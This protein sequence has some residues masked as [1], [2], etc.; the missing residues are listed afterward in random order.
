MAT[1]QSVQ[2]LINDIQ[3]NSYFLPEF[4]RG[5][6]WTSDQIKKFF[7]SLYR[8][9]PTG[10]FLV[11]KSENPPKVRGTTKSERGNFTKLIL[12][13]QQRLT[14]L[15]TI[16]KGTPPPWFEGKTP[17]TDLF[18]NLETEEFKYYQKTLMLGKREWIGV[19]AFLQQGIGD[20]VNNAT[21]EEKGYL[22]SHF[23][24]L[25][26]LQSIHSYEYYIQ[27][28]DLQDSLKVVDIFNLVNS[29]GTP[30][31]QADLSLALITSRWEECKEKMRG[32]AMKYKEV[33]FAFDMN[34]FTRGLAVVGTGRGVFDE[35]YKLDKED[36]IESWKSVELSLDYLIRV[37]PEHAYIDDTSVLSSLSAFFP[38]MY[39]AAKNDFKFPDEKTRD[40]FL[41]WFYTSLIWGRFSG[42]SEST[43]E[44]DLRILRETNS[45]DELIKSSALARGGNLDVRE[46]DLELQGVRSRIYQIVYVLIRSNGAADWADTSLPLYGKNISGR[47]AIEKHHIF[48]KSK[49]YKLYKSDSSY[50]KGLVN[51][52]AN[53]AFL[54][55][56]TNHDI[57]NNDPEIYLPDVPPDQLRRQYVPMDAELWKMN[58]QAYEAFLKERRR[59]L[60]EGINNFLHKLYHGEPRIHVSHDVALWRERIEEVEQALRRLVV[61][62]YRENEDDIDPKTYVPTHFQGKI[63]D[64]IKRYLKD[65]PS[66]DREVFQ[67]IENQIKF[68][69]V[70]EYCDL[71]TSSSNWSYF[72]T[73]FGDKSVLQSRFSQLQNLRNAIAHNRELTDV[74]IADGEAAILW[75]SAALRKYFVNSA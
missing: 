59:L 33:G 9:Y 13:G 16:I 25:N 27:E 12:D 10:S 43:L 6:R 46:D 70:S 69:D 68:F 29:A 39:Y 42:A 1:T 37:L 17:R 3:K 40:K 58:R 66:Q 30:L 71:A 48:P 8:R 26:Q 57:F 67:S 53:I 45:V 20:F 75:F 51:E 74:S 18:F 7:Q 54:T 62:V 35:V 36:F 4:Q 32:A 61:D 55:S 31:S 72:Q 34:F 65:N 60:A 28:I 23:S 56:V 50:E 63:Q 44:E 24:K 15:F 11:W 19:S 41:F 52:I 38:M 21:E 64:R 73:V 22:L 49:L 14:T 47:Y 2:E 5:F